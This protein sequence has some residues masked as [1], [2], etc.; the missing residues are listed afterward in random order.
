M[1]Q[2]PY[3][4]DPEKDKLPAQI[5]GIIIIASIVASLYL[6]FFVLV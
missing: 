4:Y 5:T 1:W 6:S 3:D 2:G